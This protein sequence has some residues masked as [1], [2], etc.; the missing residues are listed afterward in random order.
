TLEE[1]E[2]IL[3]TYSHGSRKVAATTK[4]VFIQT[5]RLSR[6][7]IEIPYSKI[8]SIQHSRQYSWKVLLIGAA[9]S[10]LM[11]TQHY[12]SP[13]ISRTITSKV[14]LTLTNLSPPILNMNWQYILSTI[15]ILPILVAV[16]IFLT[17]GQDG[18]GLHGATLKPIYLPRP[19]K[20]AI[21]FIRDMQKGNQPTNAKVD[22]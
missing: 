18:Y 5:G 15:W 14:T 22:V 1:P 7:T 11:F 6:N 9:L 8:T 10:L 4:R 3:Q 20:D 19:F 16:I 17:T 13:I 21:M 12:V 2:V